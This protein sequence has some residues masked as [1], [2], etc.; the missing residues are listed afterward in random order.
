[1]LEMQALLIILIENFEFSPTE[2]DIVRVYA[3]APSFRSICNDILRRGNT[4]RCYDLDGQG[5]G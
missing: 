2:V 3:G 4:H 1:M 5:T